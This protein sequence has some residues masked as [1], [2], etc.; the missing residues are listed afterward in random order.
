VGTALLERV[1]REKLPIR[2]AVVTAAVKEDLLRPVRQLKPD[3]LFIKPVGLKAL[4]DWLA[5]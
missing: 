4:V 3:A 1:R 5:W 2:V